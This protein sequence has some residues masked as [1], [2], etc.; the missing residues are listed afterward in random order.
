[1]NLGNSIAG[2]L[3]N[4]NQATVQPVHIKIVK[5]V[6]Q[7][8]TPGLFVLER[9]KIHVASTYV[10]AEYFNHTTS[11]HVHRTGN[12]NLIRDHI[13]GLANTFSPKPIKE[14]VNYALQRTNEEFNTDMEDRLQKKLREQQTL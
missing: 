1:M 14:P 7:I 13:R 3:Q 10:L 12:R 9:R 11:I 6:S 4:Y 8:K 2:M 5:D